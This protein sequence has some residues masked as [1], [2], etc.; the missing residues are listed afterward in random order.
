MKSTAVSVR[1]PWLRSSHKY[2]WVYAS[3]C[4]D[5]NLAFNTLDR[6]HDNC[7]CAVVE[8]LEALL[9]VDIHHR[10][11]AAEPRMRVVPAHYHF[12]ASD[13]LY[14]VHHILLVRRVNC[15]DA[16]TRSALWHREHIY[17]LQDDDVNLHA[18]PDCE[19]VYKLAKH[20]S[21]N[22]HGNTSST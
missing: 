4:V 11:P 6:V 3:E 10:E 17:Y 18:Y 15:F 19:V 22:L 7:D 5:Y 12:V 8:L 13:L 14:H 16:H 1:L 20:E 9:S 2:F 21:H